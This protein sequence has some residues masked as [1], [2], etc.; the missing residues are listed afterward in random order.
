[1]AARG[2][3]SSSSTRRFSWLVVAARAILLAVALGAVGAAVVLTRPEGRGPAESRKYACP[4]HP[5]VTADVA[6]ECPICGMELTRIGGAA[7]S[8]FREPAPP[9]QPGTLAVA[10][11]RI[12]SHELRAPAWVHG[13][14]LVQALLYEDEIATLAPGERGTFVA[15]AAPGARFAVQRAGAQ[16]AWDSSTATVDFQVQEKAPGVRVGMTGWLEL[17]ARPREALVVPQTAI[18]ESS[19]G[20]YV[21]A[22]S[23]DGR[24]FTRRPVRIGRTVFGLTAVISGVSEGER[25]ASRGAFFIDAEARLSPTPDQG[26]A[27]AR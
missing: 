27:V 3:G 5:Q 6:G 9:T 10:R 8:T 15:F 11:R 18:L 20:P 19:D 23:A 26:K 24:T 17:A 2:N 7:T 25:I 14:G 21:L 16:A 22:A 13:D 1:M 4:M 12:F